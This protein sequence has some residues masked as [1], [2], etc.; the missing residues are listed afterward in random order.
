MDK[1]PVVVLA[2]TGA[3]GQ[4]FVQLLADHPWFEVT[5]LAASERNVGKKYMDAC[6]W[7]I[8]GDPPPS[9]KD[10]VI[11][12]LETN[13]P[14]RI[15]FSA[16]PSSVAREVEPSF[17][18]AGYTVCSNASALRMEP[19]VPLLIPEI[20]ASHLA[21][22]KR[23]RKERGWPG[24]IVT[25]PNCT[26]TAAVMPLKPL[27][28]A[29]GLQKVFVA[30]LQ[31]ASGAGY[32]GVAS[33]DIL[34]NIIPYIPGE[35]EKI[36][37]ETRRLLGHMKGDERVDANITISAHANRVPVVDGHTVCLSVGFREKPTVE[38]AIAALS[39]YQGLDPDHGLPSAPK[40]PILV[41][42]RP[43]RPQP[44]R[45]RDTLGGM[46]A[47][48]GRVRPCQL[49]DLRLVSTIHNTLRGAASGS[50]LNAELLVKEGYVS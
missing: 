31:A 11:R 23:Q 24:L 34:D 44:R 10:M 12:P 37:N 49:L 46:V 35:E 15:V 32:P 48:V 6:Q 38:G 19:D 33:L 16:L 26:T 40:H 13:L 18:Q 39:E 5:A 41:T 9:L 50:I 27:D 4:R 36:E 45:D 17:A 20:N 22:I 7:V 47:T 28:D 30:T 25:S 21:L 42:T 29:F 14:A 43:D 3:V 1:I 8:P 2:A